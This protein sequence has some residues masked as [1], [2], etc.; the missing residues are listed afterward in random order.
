MRPCDPDLGVLCAVKLAWGQACE[1]RLAHT[2]RCRVREDALV[3]V[4]RL[5]GKT[6]ELG[7][8][9][10]P[11]FPCSL[12]SPHVAS[13]QLDE[14]DC[15][16][17]K[18]SWDTLVFG[19]RRLKDPTWR[20]TTALKNLGADLVASV[21]RRCHYGMIRKRRKE[22]LRYK[23]LLATCCADDQNVIWSQ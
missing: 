2:R 23:L 13:V 17:G 5:G 3:D 14:V 8:L 18:L 15:A 7:N 22:K 4:C 9:I 6:L 20:R 10:T 1:E 16:R 21:A 19:G 12:P 11:H